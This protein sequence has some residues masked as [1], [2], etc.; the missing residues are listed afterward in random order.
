MHEGHGSR[1]PQKV[2]G[3][4]LTDIVSV[5]IGTVVTMGVALGFWI[6]AWK[7]TKRMEM[8]GD[9]PNAVPRRQKTPRR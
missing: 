3:D 9:E 4:T 2:D 1:P 6:I 8:K 7:I 5:I